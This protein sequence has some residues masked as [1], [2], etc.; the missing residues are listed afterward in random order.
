MD[1][2]PGIWALH[3]VDPELKYKDPTRYAEWRIEDVIPVTFSEHKAIHNRYDREHNINTFSEESIKK[4]SK[5]RSEESKHNIAEGIRKF[6]DLLDEDEKIARKNRMSKQA[7]ERWQDQEYRQKMYD[8]YNEERRVKSADIMR[9]ISLEKWAD[10]EWKKQHCDK[11]SKIMKEHW[12]DEAYAARIKKSIKEFYMT[13]ESEK[14]RKTISEKS[15]ANWADKNYKDRVGAA[16]KK[17][18]NTEEYKAKAS[19]IQSDRIWYTDGKTDIKIKTNM[20]PPE[21]FHKGRSNFSFSKAVLK[22]DLDG[23]VLAEF[24]SQGDAARSMGLKSQA[25]LSTAIKNQS[26]YKGFIWKFK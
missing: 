12:Q 2:E 23:N 9:K 8:S 19:E 3:H 16:I 4:R 13:D 14:S 20:Q 7:K 1:F 21:G 6:W 11:L 5:E 26:L 24:D 25:N 10:E 15:K 17:S 18:L 22:C